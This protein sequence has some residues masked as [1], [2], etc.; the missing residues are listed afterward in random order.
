MQA[1]EA[2]D[3]TFYVPPERPWMLRLRS[4]E[5]FRA[6]L[7]DVVRLWK[8]HAAARGDDPEQIDLS[9]VIR[10]F[11]EVGI[12]GAFAD[13]GGRPKTEADWKAVT[14]ALKASIESS[15]KKR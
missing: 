2:D 3:L 11:L 6:Q 13:Y 7:E 5:S 14:A 10:R 9:Y 15:A 4:T 12:E 1:Q 8:A